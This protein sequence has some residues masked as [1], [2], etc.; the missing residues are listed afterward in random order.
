V[1][2]CES[3]KLTSRTYKKKTIEKNNEILS[4]K[5]NYKNS[6]RGKEEQRTKTT[7]MTGVQFLLINNNL[8][9]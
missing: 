9:L 4:I 7:K 3:I 8:E 5:K 6:K 2:I 1:K